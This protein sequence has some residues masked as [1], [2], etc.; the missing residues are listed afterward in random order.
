M[1]TDPDDGPAVELGA[2]VELAVGPAVEWGQNGDGQRDL[3]VCVPVCLF[4]SVTYS[5]EAARWPWQW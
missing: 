4:V 2:T 1:V 5:G 3:S